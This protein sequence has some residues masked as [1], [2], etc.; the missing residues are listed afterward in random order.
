MTRW[1]EDDL[2]G[3]LLEEQG[4]QWTI[5]R[6]PA[7]A[8]TQDDRDTANKK[9]KM[10]T[11]RPDPLGREPGEAL[12]PSRFSAPE[13]GRI[14]TD[15]G[16]MVWSAEYQG[17]PTRP[18]GNRIKR[19]WLSQFVDVA[20]V[21][22]QRVRY[23]DV[24]ATEDGGAQTAGVL[25]A[26]DKSGRIYIEDAICGQWG[27]DERNAIM[28]AAAEL[29]S[30]RSLTSS[31]YTR[32]EQE[33]GSSGKDAVLAILRLLSGF[34]VRPDRVTGSKDVRL[35][36]FIA[37][38]EAGNVFVVRGPWNQHFINELCSIP[39]GQFRDQGDATSGAFNT[40]TRSMVT[41]GKVENG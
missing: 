38:A 1:H 22:A 31:V 34:P 16:T 6:L 5:L 18:E 32:V 25:I 9:N 2:V 30:R 3:A 21:D 15:V 39:F 29:D 27:T 26:R 8:E 40:L 4:E 19:A 10:A 35:E 37:Q 12:C 23:W 13:L 33:P 17:A 28:K 41:A 20:P 14:K 7:L 36:P 11:G 24:A